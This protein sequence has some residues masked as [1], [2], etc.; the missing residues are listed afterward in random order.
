[1]TLHG[2]VTAEITYTTVHAC[3]DVLIWP[4]TTFVL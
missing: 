1:M 2:Y 3:H 4:W